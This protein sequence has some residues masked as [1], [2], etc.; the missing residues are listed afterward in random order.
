MRLHRPLRP[1][2]PTPATL[3]VTPAEIDAARAAIPA[4]LAAALDLAATRIEAFHRA[5][6]PVDMQMHDDAGLTMGLRWT[7]LDASA[8]TCP[9]ARRPIRP[10]C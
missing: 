8:S 5:Q 2:P 3:R 7:P 6:M 9:A 1:P 10:R 4:D